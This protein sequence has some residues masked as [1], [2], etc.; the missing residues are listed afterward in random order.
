MSKSTFTQC[1][2]LINIHKHVFLYGLRNLFQHVIVK[3]SEHCP[4][5]GCMYNSYSIEKYRNHRS[6]RNKTNLIYIK[7]RK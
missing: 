3:G 5:N 1:F 2:K 4:D 6:T 7:V